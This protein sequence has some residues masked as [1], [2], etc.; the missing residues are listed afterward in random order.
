MWLIEHFFINPVVLILI[1]NFG[2]CRFWVHLIPC[3]T[4]YPHPLWMDYIYYKPNEQYFHL[5]KLAHYLAMLEHLSNTL[6]SLSWNTRTITLRKK[7]NS[8]FLYNYITHF[9]EKTPWCINQFVYLGI[10]NLLS[11]LIYGWVLHKTFQ[12]AIL[13]YQWTHV[14]VPLP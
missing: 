8:I 5:I 10:A 14:H 7:C 12:I 4:Q 2:I 6:L 9:H 1:S 13:T 3:C 11:S